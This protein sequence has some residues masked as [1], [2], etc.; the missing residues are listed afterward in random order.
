MIRF[1]HIGPVFLRE[2]KS[3]Y[4]QNTKI[5][6]IQCHSRNRKNKHFTSTRVRQRKSEESKKE[7][8]NHLDNG[9]ERVSKESRSVEKKFRKQIDFICKCFEQKYIL[10]TVKMLFLFRYVWAGDSWDGSGTYVPL[11]N[12]Y[13][14]S[15]L[16]MTH[17]GLYLFVWMHF[18]Y[19]RWLFFFLVQFTDF[20]SL[21]SRCESPAY[22]RHNFIS[23]PP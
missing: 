6:P 1:G 11:H 3:F 19:Y 14:L 23:R 20:F 17:C 22:M 18:D 12:D 5:F 9:M 15:W 16:L 7:K 8:Q 13:S 2:R 21:T 10:S 4:F